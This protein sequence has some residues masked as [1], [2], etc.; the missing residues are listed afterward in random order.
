MEELKTLSEDGVPDAR[1]RALA[2]S[3]NYKD[4]AFIFVHGY[5]TSFDYAIYRTAQIAYDLKFDGAAVRLQLAVRR[6]SRE[7]HL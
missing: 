6:R 4:H 7:L 1:A 2:E 3:A 5:N